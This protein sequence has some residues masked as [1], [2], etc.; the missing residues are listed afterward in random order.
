MN[1][2][3]TLRPLCTKDIFSLVKIISKFGINE[4]KTCIK[5]H[6]FAGM[7]GRENYRATGIAVV[8]EIFEIAAQKLP[9]CEKE[10]C[11][12]LGSLSGKTAEEIAE[13]SPV[14]TL[15]MIKAVAEKDEF[16][17]FFMEISELFIAQ[18]TE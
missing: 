15:R 10:I 17:D 3:F 16:A 14:I 4:I 13:Q 5:A 1:N 18:K 6:S 9:D 8:F 11:A 7:A 12:F 2:E